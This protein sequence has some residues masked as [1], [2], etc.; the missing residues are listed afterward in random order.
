MKMIRIAYLV[1]RARNRAVTI[2]HPRQ[3]KDDGRHLEHQHHPQQHPRV[4]GRMRLRR[5][6]GNCRSRLLKMPKNRIVDGNSR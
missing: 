5:A 6:A 4:R 3:E 2:A 1:F